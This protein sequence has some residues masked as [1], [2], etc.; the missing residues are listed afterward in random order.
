MTNKLTATMQIAERVYSLAQEQDDPTLMIGAYNGL[1][2]TLYYLGDFESAR[3]YAMRGVQIWRSGSVRSYAIEDFHAPVVSCLYHGA[4]CEWHLG[5]IASC[6]AH[7]AEAISIA[8]ELKDMNALALALNWAANLG[9]L[10]RNPAEVDRLASELIELCTRYGFVQLLTSANVLRGWARSA[11][12]D[13][14]EA[15]PWIEQAISDN[16]AM[17]TVLGLSGFL[18]LKSEVLHLADRTADALEAISEAEA[19]AERSE[20]RNFLSALHRRRGVFLTALGADQTQIEASFSE[21]IRIAREQKS[22]SLEKR[23]EGT[24]AEYRKLRA[25]ASGGRG[26]RLPL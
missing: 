19:L 4:M 16:R 17:G 9:I 21:A 23:A 12:G 10:E 20:Q 7:I 22:S 14:A 5:E 26:F 15:I 24:Y 6:Q 8:K 3:Q 25:S 2:C 1:A 18:A 11:S 13:V